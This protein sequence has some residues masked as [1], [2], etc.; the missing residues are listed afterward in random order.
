[1]Y[2]LQ[3]ETWSGRQSRPDIRK[4]SWDERPSGCSRPT[5]AGF[6]ESATDSKAGAGVTG[7]TPNHSDRLILA[8][9]GEAALPSD[10]SLPSR[11]SAVFSSDSFATKSFGC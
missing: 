11:L 8:F 7:N 4:R 3:T 5:P 2:S 9:S 1:M 10:V 6:S